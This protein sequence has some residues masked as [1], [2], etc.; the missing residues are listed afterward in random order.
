MPIN[1]K[2]R[3]YF[4]FAIK[5]NNVIY[6]GD[7]VIAARKGIYLVV[8]SR[9]INRTTM[10]QVTDTCDAKKI[11]LFV[12]NTEFVEEVSNK[13]NCKCIAVCE[14]NLAKAIINELN[15]GFDE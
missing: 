6:G 15:G 8:C 14:P 1:N 13:I 9:D 12:T 3:S 11:K 5:S 2:I 7:N 4:G 10:K